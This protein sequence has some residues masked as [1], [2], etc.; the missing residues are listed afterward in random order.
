M[1]AAYGVPEIWFAQE[2]R[3]AL[4][5]TAAA[6]TKAGLR[7]VVVEGRTSATFPLRVPRPRSPSRTTTAPHSESR[8]RRGRV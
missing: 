4:E 7:T 1:K 2:D 8:R 5:E 3:A 6:L